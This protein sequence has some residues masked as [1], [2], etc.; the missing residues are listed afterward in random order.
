MI[1]SDK[2]LSKKTNEIKKLRGQLLILENK[3]PPHFNEGDS[4]QIQRRLKA[5]VDNL[6]TYIRQL[7][8]EQC[9]LEK[10]RDLTCEKVCRCYIILL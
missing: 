5:E 7:E 4:M 10:Q 2:E 6:E 9:D 3:T 1:I 8:T